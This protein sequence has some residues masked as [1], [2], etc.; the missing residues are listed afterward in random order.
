MRH[1]HGCIF[2]VRDEWRVGEAGCG[3]AAEW[4]HPL[5][6]R[7]QWSAG[8]DVCDWV[9]ACVCVCVCVGGASSQA[10]LAAPCRGVCVCV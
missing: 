1:V 2:T 9:C 3:P 4:L 8:A 10:V 6:L 7:E 5:R